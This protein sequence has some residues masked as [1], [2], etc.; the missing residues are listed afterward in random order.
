MLLA[1][2]GGTPSTAGVAL[3]PVSFGLRALW[4]GLQA[5]C[6]GSASQRDRVSGRRFASDCPSTRFPLRC[7]CQRLT[8][9]GLLTAW[10]APAPPSWLR[11]RHFV[12][13]CL[14]N[15]TRE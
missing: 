7:L 13:C 4:S 6:S 5:L 11:R 8:L 3:S 9:L 10:F 12:R 2:V 1:R 15:V 14:K